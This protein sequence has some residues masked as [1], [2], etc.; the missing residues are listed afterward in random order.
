[1]SAGVG[2]RATGGAL[3]TWLAPALVGV[4]L[5]AADTAP[6]AFAMRTLR[7]DSAGAA[8]RMAAA[9]AAASA[10]PPFKAAPPAKASGPP[11]QDK[12][13]QQS[14]RWRGAGVPGQELQS[15]E[16]PEACIARLKIPADSRLEGLCRP[17]GAHAPK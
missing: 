10:P 13:E 12:V 9:T 3:R 16:T 2:R 8:V 1:M 17:A 14:H 5:A 7:A 4:A 11:R 6:V 15:G